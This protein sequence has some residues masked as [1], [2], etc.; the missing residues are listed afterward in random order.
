MASRLNPYIQFD[1]SAREAMEFYKDVFGGELTTN[2]FAEFGASHGPDDDEKL[3]HAQ[4]ETPSGFTLMAADTP[5]GMSYN[6][7]ENIAVSLS[8]DDGDDLRGYYEKLSEGGK[9]SVPLEKQMWGDEFGMVT[10]RFGINWMVNIAA[11]S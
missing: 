7:G 6:P 1:G 4:L 8:G 5:Q 10:D 2:T 11:S 3:M 9:V